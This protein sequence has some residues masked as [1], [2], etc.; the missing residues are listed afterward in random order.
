[1][2]KYDELI[3]KLCERAPWCPDTE[4]KLMAEAANAIA[5]LIS[6]L[7]ASNDVI[8]KNK[9]KWINV[10][11]ALPMEDCWT[12]I[13]DGTEPVLDMWEG[14]RGMPWSDDEPFLKSG[15]YHNTNNPYITH[16]MPIVEPEPPKDGE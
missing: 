6:A 3:S 15:W 2:M 12:W 5:D 4:A 9:P 10:H 11:D 8:V 13:Y 1:M 7:Q 14:E 16:W